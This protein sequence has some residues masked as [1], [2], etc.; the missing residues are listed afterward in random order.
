MQSP[1]ANKNPVP[2]NVQTFTIEEGDEANASLTGV[3]TESEDGGDAMTVET[4]SEF[5]RKVDDIAVVHN[6]VDYLLKTYGVIKDVNPTV[7]SGL[8]RSED[9]AVW[10]KEKAGS[11]VAATKMEAPLKR[12]DSAAADGVVRIGETTTNVRKSSF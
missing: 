3:R 7:K 5:I 1:A 11:V 4:R 12:L 6:T 10:L 2:I 8:Q 9:V